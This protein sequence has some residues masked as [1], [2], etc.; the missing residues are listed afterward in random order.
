MLTM[1]PGQVSYLKKQLNLCTPLNSTTQINDFMS[2]VLTGYAKFAQLNLAVQGYPFYK[3]INA[4][5]AQ[6]NSI[7]VLGAFTSLSK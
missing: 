5:I 2:T 3:L 7:A 6:N 1:S 4:T